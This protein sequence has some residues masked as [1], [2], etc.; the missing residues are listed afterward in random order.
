MPVNDAAAATISI[1]LRDGTTIDLRDP[2]DRDRQVSN[3]GPLLTLVE[4]SVDVLPTDTATDIKPA[5]EANASAIGTVEVRKQRPAFTGPKP[6]YDAVKRLTDIVVGATVLIAASPALLAAIVAVKV[7][8]PGPVFFAQERVGRNGRS[9]K[10]LKIRS[11]FIDA[12]HRQQRAFNEAE[13]QGHLGNL[14]D[15]QLES[16]PRITPVGAILRKTSIDE[17]PQLVNVIKGDMSLVGPRPSCEWE[18]ELFE[19]RFQQ[20]HDVLPGITGLWQVEGRRTIDMVGMLELDVEYVQRRS[21][22]LDLKILARTLPAV[23]S[24]TGAG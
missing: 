22:W 16:D 9:F 3:D 12:D 4:S 10:I 13:L 1:D 8:S 5:T 20:R 19:P 11:M 6:I 2:G 15:F 24:G 17:L 7:T 21:T 18:V 23:V 14:E